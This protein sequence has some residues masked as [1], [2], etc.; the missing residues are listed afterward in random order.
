M[1]ENSW[2]V[3]IASSNRKALRQIGDTVTLLKETGHEVEV[4]YA[5]TISDIKE[6]TSKQKEIFALIIID[7]DSFGDLKGWEIIKFIRHSC[8]N[9]ASRI[10]IFS[11][12]SHDI[13]K[14]V[15]YNISDVINE[16]D[17]NKKDIVASIHASLKSFDSVRSI[18]NNLKLLN[19][20]GVGKDKAS[21]IADGIEE[22]KR[23][24]RQLQT[25]LDSLLTP[26]FIANLESGKILF[27]NNNAKEKF[28]ITGDDISKLNKA[29]LHASAAEHS[30]TSKMVQEKG[31]LE[32]YGI[33]MLTLDGRKFHALKSSTI[34][35][36]KDEQCILS[37]FSDISAQKEKEDGLEQLAAIDHL[38]GINNRRQFYHLGAIEI[39]RAKRFGYKMSV[40]M[41]DIDHFK[42]IN[43]KYG[44][45][46]G[47]VALK[48]LSDIF[49]NI[50]REIDIC[51]RMGGEEFAII[52]PQTDYEAANKMAARLQTEIA[53]ISIDSDDGKFGFTVSIGITQ[54]HEDEK[55]EE[56]L[57]RAD[58]AL[59]TAKEGG[60]NLVIT[61]P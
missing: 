5:Q 19:R 14:Q 41:I 57:T 53:N 7:F 28:A 18:E 20:N 37:S 48:R 4:H 42:S 33:D 39:H 16:A 55:I 38:T 9:T 50:L 10:Y 27:M 46:A 35:K 40:I 45:D 51:G 60:R 31:K 3:L 32:G 58:K 22:L 2:E 49:Q 17:T 26:V 6:K 43:D 11:E 52:L 44:H 56:A 25:V 24:E 54:L 8:N 29:M 34:I 59:L 1:D 47:D 12:E 30:A 23:S 13:S 15:S 61:L 21:T 36:Y